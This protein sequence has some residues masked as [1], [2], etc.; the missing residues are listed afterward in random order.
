MLLAGCI[1]YKKVN[2][3]LRSD[4]EEERRHTQIVTRIVSCGLWIENMPSSCSVNGCSGKA[5][6][7][8]RIVF[9]FRLTINPKIRKKWVEKCY[10]KDKFDPSTRRICSNHFSP[11]QFDDIVKLYL[12]DTNSIAEKFQPKLKLKAEAVPNCNFPTA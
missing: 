4:E 6:T 9:F 3:V 5:T 11:E 12:C 1:E 10:R 8:N 2:S 7:G